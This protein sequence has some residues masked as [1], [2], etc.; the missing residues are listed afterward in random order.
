M[1]QVQPEQEKPVKLKYTDPAY[2]REYYHRHNGYVVCECGAT[3]T[4][5][6]LNRHS[7]QPKHLR[8]L[9]AK[10]LLANQS[11]EIDLIPTSSVMIDNPILNPN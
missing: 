10:N 3:V 2:F 4:A 5:S 1:S 8:L 11:S 9:T 7:K 6:Y